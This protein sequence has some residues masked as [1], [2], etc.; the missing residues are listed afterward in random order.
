MTVYWSSRADAQAALG[1]G[2]E[3]SLSVLGT[4]AY[5]LAVAL[6]SPSEESAPRVLMT[7]SE[8]KRYTA[9]AEDMGYV[10]SSAGSSVTEP[11]RSASSDIDRYAKLHEELF[12]SKS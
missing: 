1:V 2:D 5:R 6:S 4:D 7:A 12:P 3:V 8:I 11:S 10:K 9:M